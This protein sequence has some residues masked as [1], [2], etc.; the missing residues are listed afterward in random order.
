[1]LGARVC[2]REQPQHAADNFVGVADGPHVNARHAIA[3]VAR[4]EDLDVAEE[5]LGETGGKREGE[6]RE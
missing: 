6:E 1:M 2:T 5:G 3:L 4:V